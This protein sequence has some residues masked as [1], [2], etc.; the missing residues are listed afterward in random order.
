[1]N[2]LNFD[3]WS[4]AVKEGFDAKIKDDKD[5][6]DEIEIEAPNEDNTI[7]YVVNVDNDNVKSKKIIS[8]ENGEQEEE[9][10]VDDKKLEN[11]I[12]D[13]VE[14]INDIKDR[15][16]AEELSRLTGG[17]KS[18]AT[19]EIKKIYKKNKENNNKRT[20]LN[21]FTLPELN[22]FFSS[23]ESGDLCYFDI[24]DKEG[25]YVIDKAYVY[26]KIKP[27][28]GVGKGEYFLPLL[29]D[30][31]YKQK[32]YGEDTKGDNYIL[33]GGQKYILELKS[34]GSPLNFKDDIIDYI[35]SNL[36]KTNK[37]DIYKKA[38]TLTILKY[39]KN[40]LKYKKDWENF[41]MC[42]FGKNNG[43]NDIPNDV[44]FINLSNIKDY[45]IKPDSYEKLFDKFGKVLN[46]IE[47]DNIDTYT[48][49]RNGKHKKDI[50]HAFTFTYIREN[51]KDSI[52]CKLKS[53]SI[54]IQEK[55][56]I[57][58]RDNFINEYYTK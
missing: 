16:Q 25:K 47:I 12:I 22:N 55:S 27:K 4:G 37:T 7:T 21:L 38:I 42:I 2:I 13:A 58:S 17:D 26:N 10:I 39:A 35:E 30:D 1:M 52:I 32:I 44:L 40:Q 36:D 23:S 45:E 57:L 54:P 3:K 43:E 11:D 48:I 33:H 5:V 18:E 50:A 29:F 41:Y 56:L 34:P 9:I 8:T 46:I 14:K 15:V 51:N 19:K 6:N 20:S 53:E 49:G 24:S 28:R 31:V